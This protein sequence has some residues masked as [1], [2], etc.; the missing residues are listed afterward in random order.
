MLM[1]SPFRIFPI[2]LH[3]TKSQN[4][5]SK[6]NGLSQQGFKTPADSYKQTKHYAT[7]ITRINLIYYNAQ[8]G[9]ISNPPGETLFQ[10]IHNAQCYVFKRA[11]TVYQ[12]GKLSLSMFLKEQIFQSNKILFLLKKQN[13]LPVSIYEP[14]M[15]HYF[16]Y[17]EI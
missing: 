6:K 10:Y 11:I 9:T 4:A 17:V 12:S 1:T 7:K 8:V 15:L 3:R 14:L 5:T 13:L 16:T 2:N